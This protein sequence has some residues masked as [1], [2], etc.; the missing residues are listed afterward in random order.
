MPS[1]LFQKLSTFL[2]KKIIEVVCSIIFHCI[3]YITHS[4]MSS[5][6]ITTSYIRDFYNRLSVHVVTPICLYGI[7]KPNMEYY[8]RNLKFI[9]VVDEMFGVFVIFGNNLHFFSISSIHIR[10]DINISRF[11]REIFYQFEFSIWPQER[12]IN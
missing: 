12:K 4:K 3:W 9:C 11:Y 6:L 1:I 5:L 10:I 8:P 2:L 7:D